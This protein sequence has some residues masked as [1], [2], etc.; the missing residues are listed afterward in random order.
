MPHYLFWLAVLIGVS[1][2]LW[3]ATLGHNYDLESYWIASEVTLHGRSVYVETSRYNYGP[4]WFLILGAFRRALIAL[5]VDDIFHFHLIIAAFLTLVDTTIAFA[6]KRA[7]GIR[8]ALFFFL[9][10]VSILITGYHSQFDNLAILI[11]LGACYFLT[12]SEGRG[13]RAFTLGTALLGISLATKHLLFLF[14]VWLWGLYRKVGIKVWIATALIPWGIFLLCFAP[15]LFDIGGA[16]AII[17]HVVFYKGRD[18]AYLVTRALDLFC[19]VG[20]VE[21]ALG[22]PVVT[23]LFLLIVGC[24]GFLWT[25]ARASARSVEDLFSIYLITLVAFSSAMANQYLAIPLVALARYTYFP[26]WIYSIGATILLLTNVDGVFGDRFAALRFIDYSHTQIWL[27]L[28]LV[29]IWKRG[30][31]GRGVATL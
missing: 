20:L 16:A 2:R 1:S 30:W 21:K 28:L 24:S 12:R 29:V 6:I 25:S 14:P 8:A 17:D 18:G 11:G 23:P 19:D 9:N 5:S 7:W 31:S 15:F 22:F 26:S 4:V 27:A 10:P 13:G 3:L